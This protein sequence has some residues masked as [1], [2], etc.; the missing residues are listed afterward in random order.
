MATWIIVILSVVLL[1]A[2]ATFFTLSFL[3]VTTTYLCK[4]NDD[5]CMDTMTP[6][7]VVCYKKYYAYMYK[8]QYNKLQTVVKDLN[9]TDIKVF[10]SEGYDSSKIESALAELLMRCCMENNINVE[11]RTQVLYYLFSNKPFN[12]QKPN[13]TVADSVSNDE[14]DKLQNPGY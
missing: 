9:L 14:T 3:I 13:E 7:F 1:V 6:E 2:I 12:F 5:A 8:H 4:E 11:L 10:N